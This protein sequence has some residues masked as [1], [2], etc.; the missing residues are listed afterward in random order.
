MCTT[1]RAIN[2]EQQADTWGVELEPCKLCSYEYTDPSGDIQ[3][4]LTSDDESYS[5]FYY[6][7]D[8]DTDTEDDYFSPHFNATPR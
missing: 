5:P 2:I 4:S 1:N 3:R 6:I 8:T 7:S